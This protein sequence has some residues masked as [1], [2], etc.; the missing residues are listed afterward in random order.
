MG[1]SSRVIGLVGAAVIS[2]F[3]ITAN[4]QTYPERPVRIVVAFSAGGGGDILARLLAQKLSDSWGQR[5]FVENRPG[6]SG[7]PGTA[8]V[9]E[10]AP[11]GY[12]LSLGFD[13]NFVINP[14]IYSKLPYDPSRD[15]TPVTKLVDTSIIFV[16]HP[17]LP[18][19]SI[20]ELVELAKSKPGVLNYAS[21]GTGSTPH[22]AG[23]LLK[24]L[25][26]ISM[27]HIAYKG[28]GQAVTDVVG[29]QVPL[30]VV[31][32]TT[33]Q[34]YIKQ[35]RLKPLAVTPLRRSSALPNVPT[36]AESGVA[37]LSGF[38]VSTW[39]GIMAPT[40]TPKPVVLKLQSQVARVLKMPDVRER[41]ASLG[42]DPV[43][44]TPEEF[45]AQ[46]TAD[47]AKW[48]KVVAQAGIKVE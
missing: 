15:L 4:P 48:A 6:A 39:W 23:E 5:V 22:L 14:L 19:N 20:A 9:A 31:G 47:K 35:G 8:V 10:A 28:G 29:G 44:N 25:T 18:A 40:A 32:L 17:S 11:D 43:G 7:I 16:A 34:G 30:F 45:A 36:V 33:V 24:V 37:A 12:T 3:H 13:G 26:G 42:F 46:M 27:V 38:D 1:V 21:P 2:G 41:L